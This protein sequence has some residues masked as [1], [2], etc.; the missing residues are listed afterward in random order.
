VTE[1]DRRAW[2]D[3]EPTFEELYDEMTLRR[4]GFDPEVRS[5]A[6]GPDPR[7]ADPA[8][9]PDALGAP[10]SP[11]G[12]EAAAEP[13]AGNGHRH[14]VRRRMAG[15]VL[16]GA[17]FGLAEVL[18][19]EKVADAVV[20]PELLGEPPIDQPVQFIMVPGLPK[21]S[22]VILRPWLRRRAVAPEPLVAPPVDIAEIGL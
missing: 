5:P 9:D 21:A 1:L 19:P 22:V 8:S 20:E 12:S 11:D 6:P 15:A 18:E 17:M 16:A 7:D 2:G 14:P 10:G 3:E 13:E 4:L